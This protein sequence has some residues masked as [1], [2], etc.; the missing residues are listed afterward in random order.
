MF[1][2]YQTHNK[3]KKTV[4]QMIYMAISSSD[5][6]N[7][8]DLVFSSYHSNRIMKMEP[9]SLLSTLT[10]STVARKSLTCV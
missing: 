1:T 2:V 4:I 8:T 9:N 7:V 5:S 3:N 6:K 10:I